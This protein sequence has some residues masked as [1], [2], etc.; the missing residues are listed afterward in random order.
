MTQ[1]E[2]TNHVLLGTE[3]SSLIITGS[4]GLLFELNILKK[5]AY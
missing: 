1:N 2:V 5:T 4:F 3:I